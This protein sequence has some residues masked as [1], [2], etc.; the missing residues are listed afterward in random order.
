MRMVPMILPL[1]L[2]ARPG[3]VLST[4]TCL[5]D[6]ELSSNCKGR[7]HDARG[8]CH[9]H[10]APLATIRNRLGLQAGFEPRRRRGDAA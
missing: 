7:E 1:T 2:S 4:G 3:K 8:L 10:K 9:F 6:F 5:R